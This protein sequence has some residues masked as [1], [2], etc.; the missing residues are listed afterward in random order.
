MLF[1]SDYRYYGVY[2]SYGRRFYSTW[3]PISDAWQKFQNVSAYIIESIH[4]VGLLHLLWLRK[5][6]WKYTRLIVNIALSPTL[7]S[8]G[9]CEVWNL[10]QVQRVWEVLLLVH[11]RSRY[12]GMQKKERNLDITR[13]YISLSS[14]VYRRTYW[15]RKKRLCFI[16]Y[17]VRGLWINHYRKF[18]IFSMSTKQPSH[19][20]TNRHVAA[21]VFNSVYSFSQTRS[22]TQSNKAGLWFVY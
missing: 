14:S 1:S 5:T 22:L 16:Y 21:A 8:V 9:L 17:I 3:L 19:G 10:F 2:L 20:L 11:V 7:K 12:V 18:L 6:L 15:R 13:V 4:T